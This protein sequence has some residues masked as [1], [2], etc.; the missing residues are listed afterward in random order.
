MTNLLMLLP[1][2]S[3]AGPKA[4]HVRTMLDASHATL[5]SFQIPAITESGDSLDKDQFES[6]Q[7]QHGIDLLQVGEGFRLREVI[8]L[9][10]PRRSML[11]FCMI[12]LWSWPDSTFDIGSVRIPWEK[13]PDPRDNP[14]GRNPGNIWSFSEPLSD[15]IKGFQTKFMESGPSESVSQGR[16]DIAALERLIKCHTEKGDTVYIWGDAGDHEIISRSAAL[17]SRRYAAIPSGAP[18]QFQG[19]LRPMLDSPIQSPVLRPERPS[20]PRGGETKHP[21]AEYYITD[22]RFGLEHIRFPP[23]DDVVT[24]PPYN[25]GYR[26]FNV[27]KL[28]QRTRILQ[29]PG[30]KGY[31]DEMPA[32]AYNQLIQSTFHLIDKRLGQDSADVFVNL[33][34]DYGDSECNPPFWIISLVPRE[35]AFSDLLVWRYDISYDPAKAKYKPYY[36]W[37]FRFTK[38]EIHRRPRHRYL[39]D[40]Y[41]PILKGNSVERRDLVSPAVY[42]KELVR[43][44]LSECRHTGLVLDP[45]LGSGTTIAAS[46]ELHRPSIGFEI[47]E[48]YVHDIDLRL[49]RARRLANS[50]RS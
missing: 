49:R 1:T 16:I 22:C 3:S 25:I 4:E 18:D 17:L 41:L 24:S 14:L 39:R 9:K 5:A 12:H 29:T 15:R 23:I 19:H 37:I 11:S 35:W 7:Y 21:P 38:G 47:N 31:D 6:F 27:P 42:P 48:G 50:H 10:L 30:R 8:L 32:A 45:F 33:K 34:N 46:W 44:C 43:E 40:F 2:T 20:L 26:P 36:E 13:E 28:N